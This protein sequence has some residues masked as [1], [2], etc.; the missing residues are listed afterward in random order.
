[1]IG[2]AFA[3]SFPSASKHFEN[4]PHPHHL[5]QQQLPSCSFRFISVIITT[6]RLH[7]LRHSFVQNPFANQSNGSFN[8]RH[9]NFPHLHSLF[10]TINHSALICSS[11]SDPTHSITVMVMVMRNSCFTIVIIA[12]Y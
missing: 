9:T 5:L 2:I 3:S 6:P 8:S 7:W 1:M 11:V 12:V 10:K 4:V